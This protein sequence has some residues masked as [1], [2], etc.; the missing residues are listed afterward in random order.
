MRGVA[1]RRASVLQDAGLLLSVGLLLGLGLLL[2]ACGHR[3]PDSDGESAIN[4]YPTNYKS[5][6]LGAMHAYLNNPTGIRDA[7]ISEP[8]IK[9]ISGTTRYVA[10][11]KFNAK[12]N[13]SND[14]AGM[15][16]IAA[17]FFEGRFDQFVEN[18]KDICAGV[19]YAPF[20]ELQKLPP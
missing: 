1:A 13:G 20:P 2:C 19:T 5:D 17:A 11:L 8:A 4:V 15:R 14:Y 12:R 6:I 10:C 16:E 7:V 3:Q 9:T 18:T